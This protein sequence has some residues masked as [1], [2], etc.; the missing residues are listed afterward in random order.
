LVDRLKG[1]KDRPW[2]EFGRNGKGLTQNTLARLLKPYQI[3][4]AT[5]R[6]GQGEKDTAKGYKL[7]QFTDDFERF[8]PNPSDE[9][10]TPSQANETEGFSPFQT[11]TSEPDVTDG[12]LKKAN[13]SAECDGVTD[14]N[15]PLTQDE[16][17]DLAPEEQTTL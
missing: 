14:G 17:G 12:K 15:V 16:Y 10:V 13:S 8:L 1:L 2:D 4:P 11:V 6:M 9:T 7:S 3:R 5:I